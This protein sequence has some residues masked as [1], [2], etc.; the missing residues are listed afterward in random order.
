[1]KISQSQLGLIDTFTPLQN[2]VYIRVMRDKYTNARIKVHW[3]D[4]H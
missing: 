1:M 4:V 3:S 2:N